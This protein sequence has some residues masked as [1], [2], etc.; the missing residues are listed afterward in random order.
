MKR[1]I[2]LFAAVLLESIGW[3]QTMVVTLNDGTTTKYDMNKVKSIEFTDEDSGNGQET[4]PSIIG[5]WKV[6]GHD[7]NNEKLVENGGVIRAEDWGYLQFKA[8]GHLISIKKET[9]PKV[10]KG[11]WQLVDGTI[12]CQPEVGITNNIL[13]ISLESDKLTIKYLFDIIFYL[14]RVPDSEIEKYL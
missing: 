6:V 3:S 11:T 12:I 1:V 9:S 2:L 13:I 7:S 14:I 5:T 8:D 4:T 10:T